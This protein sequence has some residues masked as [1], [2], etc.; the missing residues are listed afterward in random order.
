MEQKVEWDES[1]CCHN[2]N[3]VRSLPKVFAVEEGRFVIRP[4]NAPVDEV[5]KVVEACPSSAL[6]QSFS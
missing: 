2:G 1:K 5:R 3:C 6:R 4:E